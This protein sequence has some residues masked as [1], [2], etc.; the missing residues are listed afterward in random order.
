MDPYS[1]KQKQNWIDTKFLEVLKEKQGG[2][3]LEMKLLEKELE[4]NIC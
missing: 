1:E 4:F 2:I 3:N